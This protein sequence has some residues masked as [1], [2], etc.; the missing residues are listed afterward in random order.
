MS[1]TRAELVAYLKGMDLAAQ[2]ML[3]LGAWLQ[4]LGQSGRG[5]RDELLRRLRRVLRDE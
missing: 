1:Y 2:Q 3:D 4:A 5:D